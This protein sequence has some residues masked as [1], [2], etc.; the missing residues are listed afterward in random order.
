MKHRIRRTTL[1]VAL[2]ELIA[3]GNRQG[4]SPPAPSDG[5]VHEHDA[6]VVGTKDSGLEAAR[7][8]EAGR[9]ANV[10]RA[11]DAG[12]DGGADASVVV[13]IAAAGDISDPSDESGDQFATSDLM[14]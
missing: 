3:C 7:T 4:T 9:D 13:M 8:P 2:G 6:T 1:V 11:P 5:A 14:L 12:A 10:S